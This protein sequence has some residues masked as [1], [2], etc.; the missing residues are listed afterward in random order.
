MKITR[1]HY[2][3][4]CQKK[5][6]VSWYKPSNRMNL[7]TTNISI[8]KLIPNNDKDYLEASNLLSILKSIK[9]RKGSNKLVEALFDMGKNPGTISNPKRRAAYCKKWLDKIIKNKTHYPA[10]LEFIDQL[11]QAFD[12]ILSR[13]R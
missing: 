10:N 5:M 3:F 8:H 12:A 2:D 13:K 4:W 11:F 1:A 7:L 6:N 9:N